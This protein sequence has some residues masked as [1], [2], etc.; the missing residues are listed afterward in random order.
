MDS[1]SQII[2]FPLYHGTSSHYLAGFKLGATPTV[3]PHK[4]VVLGL[5]RD[6]WAALREFG[7][8][9]EWYVEHILDQGSGYSNWQHGELYV[10]PSKLSAVRYAGGGAA[11]GG[12]LLT[13]CRRTIDELVELDREKADR[14]MR[15][16]EGVARF[17]KGSGFPILVEFIDVRVCDLMTERESDDVLT[18][19]SHLDSELMLETL[20]QQTNFRLISGNG[21]VSRVFELEISDVNDPL[22]SFGL[23]P[24]R[25]SKLWD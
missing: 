20:G 13:L 21:T 24:I 16:A 14:L 19:L 15:N 23:I 2:S 4:G 18:A 6:A 3:W 22:T 11:Y 25:T 12:E 1:N 10:T 8:E 9:P 7:R 17:L 5:L